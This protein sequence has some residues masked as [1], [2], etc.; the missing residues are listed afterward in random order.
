M[1]ANP[2]LS[3]TK[4]NVFGIQT[5]VAISFLVKRHKQ[6]GSKIF[7]ARRPEMDTA[8]DKLAFLSSTKASAISFDRVEP[9]KKGNWINLT[10]NGWDD[11]IPVADKKTKAA[12][13]K[14]QEKA[15]FGFFRSG[16]SPIVTIGSM[17]LT[18][19]M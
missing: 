8:D 16:L 1:R 5:G 19:P 13:S 2:K 3:G 12:K 9:D 18:M 7:Y 10:E 11:L 17:A 4:H 15:I 6:T 14:A